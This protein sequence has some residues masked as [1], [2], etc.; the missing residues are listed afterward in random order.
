MMQF[1]LTVWR[2]LKKKME[3]AQRTRKKSKVL[4]S[5]VKK[6]QSVTKLMQRMKA[7]P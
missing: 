5:R 6:S 2:S 7:F 3:L 4:T 1:L